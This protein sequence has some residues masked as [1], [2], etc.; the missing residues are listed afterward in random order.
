MRLFVA[1]EL[2]ETL[3]SELGRRGRDRR[4]AY[5]PARWVDP[6]SMHLSLLFLGSVDGARQ[7]ALSD[8]L[9][10]A[11]AAF[12]APLLRPASIGAFPARGAARVVW[13]GIE[14]DA[15]L[16]SLQRAVVEAAVRA[17]ERPELIDQRPF[18]PHVTL[19]R[20]RPPWPR[21][22]V[23]ELADR[24]SAGGP[25]GEPFCCRHG[26][27]FKSDLR[28]TGAVYQPLATFDLKTA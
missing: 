20:C 23:R 14:S 19:A 4:S 10:A 3:R 28:P 5:P 27:L 22:R 12:E 8:L 13:M 18:Q 7:G 9:K 24:F 15:D 21:R 25:P 2:P 1:F 17:L 11:F 16:A 6:E 26:T